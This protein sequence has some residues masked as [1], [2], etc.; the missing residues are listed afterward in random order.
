MVR[1][2]FLRVCCCVSAGKANKTKQSNHVPEVGI[3]WSGSLARHCKTT[4][5]SS[6][7]LS[8]CF[9]VSLASSCNIPPD[10]FGRIETLRYLA[11]VDYAS[12]LYSTEKSNIA[13][14][15]RAA[16]CLL[17]QFLRLEN[18]DSNAQIDLGHEDCPCLLKYHTRFRLGVHGKAH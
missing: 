7:L 13:Y 3:Q 11:F 5:S 18:G 16:V 6:R 15:G 17:V 4:T 10:S 1:T 12:I 9:A 2:L 14:L 8:T